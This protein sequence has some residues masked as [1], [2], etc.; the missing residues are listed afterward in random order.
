LTNVKTS[1]LPVTTSA[2]TDDRIVMLCSPSNTPILETI[3]VSYFIDQFETYL[4]P[5]FANTSNAVINISLTVNSAFVTNSSGIFTTFV[6]SSIF[7]TGNG[8]GT[9]ISGVTVNTKIIAIGNTSVNAYINTSSLY[10]SGNVIANSTGANNAFNLGGT[11]ASLYQLNSTLAANIASYLPIYAGVVN[12]SSVTFGNTT[13]NN[14]VNSTAV[15]LANSIANTTLSPGKISLLNGGSSLLS[16]GNTSVNVQ[17]NST[18]I[19]VGSQVYFGNVGTQNWFLGNSTVNSYGNSTSEYIQSPLSYTFAN[20]TTV[21]IGNSTVNVFTNST[22]FFT[23]N[24]TVNGYGNS[25]AE[26]IANSTGSITLTAASITVAANALSYIYVGNTLTNTTINSTSVYI[27][28]INASA[29]AVQISNQQIMVGNT[30]TNT[31]ISGISGALANSTGTLTINP[32]SITVAANASSNISVGNSTIN[33]VINSSSFYIG[34]S[35]LYG[36]SNSSTDITANATGTVTK[37]PV[38]ISIAANASSNISV[39]NTIANIIINSTSIAIASVNATANGVFLSNTAIT[40]GNTSVNVQINPANLNIG[41]AT[42]SASGWAWLPN[43]VKMNWGSVVANSIG[44]NAVT[45]SSAFTTNAYGISLTIFGPNT[46]FGL[47]AH[48]NTISNTGLT[49]CCGNTTAMNNTGIS[50]IYYLV[51]GY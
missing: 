48:A 33:V 40:V 1:Q 13:A 12:A 49:I 24:S 26:V 30:S 7:Q 38:S 9:V 39:G 11:A 32:V 25:T 2:N 8:Y 21:T 43:G 37:T 20:S 4:S 50:S 45:F 16:V 3:P 41:T 31:T 27:G 18:A 29:V 51:T 46:A 35:T 6:N 28:T 10:I 36:L 5:N 23:G 44:V 22:H 14:I 19:N 47:C 42:L 34:N 17:V 15:Y